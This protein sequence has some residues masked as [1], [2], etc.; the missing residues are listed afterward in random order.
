MML[1]I[2]TALGVIVLACA[3]RMAA[4]QPAIRSDEGRPQV[5]WQEARQVVGKM[6]LVAGEVIGVPKVGRITFINFDERRPVRFAGVIFEDNLANFPKPPAEM[7]AG[8]IVRIRGRVSMFQDQPQIVI[9]SPEQVEVLDKLPGA[10]DAPRPVA[11]A[12]PG[13]LVV[14]AYNVLNLFDD[15][16]DPYR[17]DEGTPTK[18]REQM[19]ALAQSIESLGA[20]VIAM[21]EVENR[22]YLERFVDV[23]LPHLGYDNVVLFEGNDTRGI[24][25]ALVSRVPVGEVRSYRHL[26][27]K[28]SDGSEQHFQRD[29]LSVTLEPEGGP[30]VQ[31]WV[32]HLK[33]KRGDDDAAASIIRVAEATQIRKLLDAELAH[34]PQARIIVTGDFNDTADSTSIQTIVGAGP[35]AMWSAMTDLGPNPQVLTYNE[36]EFKSVIDYMLCSPALRQRYVK[37]SFRVPQGSIETTGSDHNPIVAT[38]QTN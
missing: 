16:D 31:V 1:R 25:V 24:D 6:A 18:P 32:V 11:R 12:K 34:D 15:V 14:A 2:C 36:G 22:D 35:T 37:G 27:F 19:E 23:F 30:P 8:K 4:G 28:G 33:S 17:D 7:Y 29:L 3:V 13:Q 38:F 21:E 5:M 10:S 9:T 20:D 26:K